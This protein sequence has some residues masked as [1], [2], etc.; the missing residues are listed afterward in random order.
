MLDWDKLGVDESAESGDEYLKKIREWE[1]DNDDDLHITEL[2]AEGL[3][4]GIA[5]E[6]WWAE[7]GPKVSRRSQVDNG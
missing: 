3:S 7:P 1:D 4:Q 2:Y 6:L 5:Y